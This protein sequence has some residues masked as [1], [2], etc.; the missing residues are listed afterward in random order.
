MPL[1]FFLS[2]PLYLAAAGALLLWQG[3]Q[4]LA[5]R[6]HPCSLAVTHLLTLGFLMPVMIGA[7]MQLLPVLAGEPVPRVESASR[8]IHRLLNLGV[9]MMIA[10]FMGAGGGWLLAGGIGVSMA[11]LVFGTALGVALVRARALS[12]VVWSMRLSLLSLLPTVA[13]GLLL[14]LA[15]GGGYPLPAMPAIVNLHL[16]W[17]L[18]GWVGLL[19]AALLAELVPM[20]YVTPA[21]PP[22]LR[23]WLG[24]ALFALLLV[25]GLAAPVADLDA[26]PVLGLLGA[27]FSAA[28]LI[29]L[30]LLQRRRRPIFDATLLQLYTGAGFTAASAVVWAFG[31]EAELLGVLL[32]GGVALAFPFGVVHKVVPFLCWFHLHGT[33][34]AAGRLDS[35]LPTVKDFIS[36]RRSRLQLAFY[37][38]ALAALL[39]GYHWPGPWARLG[40][41]LL[42]L[43]AL[44]LWANLLNA[45]MRYR[46]EMKHLQWQREA[47]DGEI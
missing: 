38:A 37:W 35:P 12:G 26:T 46:T 47:G 3:P 15:L 33:R 1:R 6:W 43:A 31:A 7:L 39:G 28:A 22:G 18:L 2:A 42:I 23:R 16:G 29:S 41:L 34:I 19:V 30:W 20:F 40:G 10:G 21:Y 8:W 17:G 13:L 45:W 5:S 32:L 9:P 36:E 44:A 11:L 24:P 27:G 14:A 4:I 25:W